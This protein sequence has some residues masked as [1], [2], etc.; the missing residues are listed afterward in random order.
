MPWTATLAM[1]RV[2]L[3]CSSAKEGQICPVLSGIPCSGRGLV[4]QRWTGTASQEG[5]A[6]TVP[7][8]DSLRRG[9]AAWLRSKETLGSQP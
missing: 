7:A 4:T 6:G 5:S 9:L 8:G 3:P 1:L 2:P